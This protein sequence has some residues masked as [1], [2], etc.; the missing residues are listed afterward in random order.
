MTQVRRLE[1]D[2]WAYA[3]IGN[4]RPHAI[5][6]DPSDPACL[7]RDETGRVT[8]RFLA[9]SGATEAMVVTRDDVDIRG[10]VMHRVGAAAD[11]SFWEVGFEP[12]GPRLVYSLAL[13]LDDDSAVYV[14]VTGVTSAVERIDR[15]EVDV[16]DIAVHDVPDWMRGSVVYQ[17]FLDRFARGERDTS[18]TGFDEWGSAP[19]SRGFQGGD[20]DGITARLDYLDELGVDVIYLNPIFRAPSNHRYDTIDY[21]EVDPMLGGE[22]ALERL[23]EAVHA[24]GMRLILDVSLN[25]VHPMATPFQDLL[26]K[27]PDSEYDGWFKVTEYP[28][29]VRYRPD[30]V[31]ENAYWKDRLAHLEAETGIPI[32]AVATGPI[33]EPTYETWYGVP[34]MPRIDLQHPPARQ[35]MIDVTTHWIRDAGIDGWRM[36]VVRYIDHNFWGDVRKAVREIR[37]DAY[38]LAE[39]M[40]DASRWLQGDEFDATMNY[41]FRQLCLDFF[42][43]NTIDANSFV[44]GYLRMLAMYSPAVTAVSHN[45]ISSH[46]MARFLHVAGEDE[47][48]LLLATAFQLTTPGAPGIYYGDELPLSGGEDPDNRRAFDWDRVGN[49]HHESVRSL[50]CLR[51]Q[52]DALRLGDITVLPV[53]DQ[54]VSFVRRLGDSALFIAINNGATTVELGVEPGHHPGETLWALG[55]VATIDGVVE[56][57]PHAAVVGVIE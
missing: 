44:G 57:G 19:T 28:L 38:L 8:F 39:V 52:H 12:T 27:G 41:T 40:G 4:L 17:I 49:P 29:K 5:G 3:R 22:A 43:K 16:A 7:S 31:A 56:L 34:Y 18:P 48:Q 14:G 21:L 37:P 32:E 1:S 24:R 47:V 30:L 6:F 15:I 26:A 10:H 11:V 20:L 54:C 36:D 35:S 53:V 50:A 2:Q 51:R 13:L 23:V 42:A 33:V 45:L 25:H 46:D 55:Q 9:P